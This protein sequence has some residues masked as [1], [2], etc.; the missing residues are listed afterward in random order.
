MVFETPQA[1][2]AEYGAKFFAAV[3]C[4]SKCKHLITH[5]GNGSFWAVL[6]RGNTENVYQILNNK[7]L[8]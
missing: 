6:Y 1:E 4:L 3:F 2:R 7:W 8:N 5:S